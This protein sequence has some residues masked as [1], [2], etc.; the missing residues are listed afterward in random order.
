MR[1]KDL[2]NPTNKPVIILTGEFAGNEGVCLGQNGDGLWA[3]SPNASDRIIMLRFDDDFGILINK[4][5]L[6]GVN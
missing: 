1:K 4:G 2:P 6:P 3:V 5:Q